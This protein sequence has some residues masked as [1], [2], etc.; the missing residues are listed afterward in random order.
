LPKARSLAKKALEIDEFLAE[1]HAS[2]AW[3][4]FF[5]DYDWT[6]SKRGFKQAIELNPGYATAHHWYAMNFMIMNRHDEAIREVKLAKNLDPLSLMINA[7]LGS[8]LINAGRWDEGLE[9]LRKT[10]EMNPQFSQAYFYIGDAY[11]EKEEYEEAITAY[12]K[13]SRIP[14]VAGLLGYAY[15]RSGEK[16]KAMRILQE[17]EE[18]SKE[19][20]I[21][22]SSVFV[23]F[24]GLGEIDKAL[25][26]A[27]KAYNERDPFMP[28]INLYVPEKDRIRSDPRFNALLKKMNLN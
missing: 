22:S 23:I 21:R 20:Y 16:D 13:A 8:H 4:S 9:Q 27:E 10:L 2:L 26:W 1:A 28:F 7:D 3:S 15:A 14:W 5:L 18:Q 25:E 24:L 6:A 19:R 17:L 11:M 12:K